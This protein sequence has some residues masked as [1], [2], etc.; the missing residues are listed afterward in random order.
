MEIRE[1][2]AEDIT[3]AV[4]RMCISANIH[5]PEDVRE[6]LE[7]AGRD[8]PWPIAA[9]GLALLKDNLKIAAEKNLPICQDTGAACLFA[10]L[11][12]DVHI[13]GDF[14]E[15]VNE[16]VRQG[17]G[18][19]YL[20]KS[21]AADP[22]FRGNTGDN[23]P[24]FITTELVPGNSLRLTLM[25]KGFGSENKSAL[26]MLHPADGTEGVV[27]FVVDTVKSAGPDPC[28]PVILGIGIGGTFDKAPQL[29]KKALLRKI[30]ERNPD[31]YYAELE[32]RILREVN[33]LGIG[34]Q[35]FGGKTTCLWAAI[36]K[37]P[38]HVAG[39]PVAVNV[40]CH[41]LRRESV[42]L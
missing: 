36:E 3:E 13:S 32:K 37:M 14:T 5:L 18:D 17:Y 33:S 12:T 21:I 38:T 29:A 20:R 24:A 42:I 25:P 28:P 15:A 41:A 4:R 40:S 10:E 34:P 9:D 27:R 6:A 31:P 11:G 23:T 30:G 35:G 8:E 7:L 26:R 1:I 2:K 19:G 39:L 16:G 22:L